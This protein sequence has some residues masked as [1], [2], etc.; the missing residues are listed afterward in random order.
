MRANLCQFRPDVIRGFPSVLAS[1]ADQITDEDRLQLRPRFLTTD[2]ENLTD[3]AR[4]QLERAF[5]APVFDTYDCYECN[6]IAY[7][8]TSGEGYHVMDQ[9]VVV[10]VLDGNRPVLPGE[11]GEVALTSLHAWAAP[12]IRYMPGDMVERGPSQCACGA[13]NTTLARVFGRTHDRFLLPSGR[14]LHPKYLAAPLR[15]IMPVLRLYQIAQEAIDRVV[16]KL[17]AVPGV[18]ISPEEIEKLRSGIARHLGED[19]ILV[20]KQVDEIPSEP[21]GK[22]RPYRSYLNRGEIS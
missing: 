10:E 3:L 21:N 18:E 4:E 2:S 1:F 6:V 14:I 8:C 11:C 7:Q 12:L 19:V 5:K 22:F 13:P 15:P 17:Q 9:S 20:V 16:V